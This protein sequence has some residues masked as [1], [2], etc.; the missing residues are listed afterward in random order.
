MLE[1]CGRVPVEFDGKDFPRIPIGRA[2]PCACRKP[3]PSGRSH[4]DHPRR[5]LLPTLILSAE[6][7]PARLRRALRND[8]VCCF[9]WHTSA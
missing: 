5:R 1:I 9:D 4:F 2:W 3:H 8:E 7:W 6:S